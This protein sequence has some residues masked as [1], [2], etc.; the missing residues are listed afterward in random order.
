MQN[1]QN[2]NSRIESFWR[3]FAETEE[4][5]RDYFADETFVDKAALVEAI[6]NRVLD[7]GLFSWTI[8]PGSGR[9]FNLTISPNGSRERLLVSKQIVAAA[10]PLPGWEFHY[11]KPP[12][13]QGLVF[14]LYDD[15]MM[16]CEVDA[17]GW[18]FV[19]EKRPEGR[20]VVIL[21]TQDTGRLGPDTL[22]MAAQQAVTNLLGEEMV[23]N[24][25]QHVEVVE[26][27]E[28][29]QKAISAPLEQLS[30]FAF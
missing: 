1:S 11:A 3:W 26:E 4:A 7:F 28:P 29:A 14:S 25:V 30:S 8:G 13:E 5:I 17:S 16:E 10:P 27:L 6:D 24:H 20:A 15:F 22:F 18:R 23:I 19:V 21:E 9:P 2:L 12:Q